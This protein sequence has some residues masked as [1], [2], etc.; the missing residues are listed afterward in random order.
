MDVPYRIRWSTLIQ[1]NDFCHISHQSHLPRRSPL[2]THD[3]A[4]V[5]WVEE[6]RAL[7]EVSGRDYPL[8][9]GTLVLVRPEDVHRFRSPTPDFAI[10]NLAFP[11][12]ELSRLGRYHHSGG[13][14]WDR[15]DR[16]PIRLSQLHLTRLH[17]LSASLGRDPTSRLG[18]DRIL[19]ELLSILDEPIPDDNTT[20]RWLGEALQAWQSSPD[21]M[22][23]GVSGL[24]ELAGRSREHVSRVLKHTTGRRAVDVL[25]HLRMDN[26]AQLL[27]MSEMPIGRI[28]SEVGLHHLGHFYRVFKTRFGTTPR[29]Y[30]LAHRQVVDPF[31]LDSIS[32]G[33]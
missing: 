26:A 32:G 19:L 31:T 10:T 3:F 9:R 11:R 16:N 28:A 25:N 30:R 8:D 27:R 29:R 22:A 33:R 6:G 17:E 24:A 7:H 23:T 14:P 4:E 20:P 5:F 1:G 13:S 18:L 21:A 12:S 2:H 15:G